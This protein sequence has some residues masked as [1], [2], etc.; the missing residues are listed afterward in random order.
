MDDDV[1]AVGGSASSQEKTRGRKIPNQG[2]LRFLK[3]D[4]PYSRTVL[5]FDKIRAAVFLT[6]KC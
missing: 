5:G 2:R 3:V 1:G 6:T 4:I